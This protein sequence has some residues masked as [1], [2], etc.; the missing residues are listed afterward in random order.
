MAGH[1]HLSR[2]RG[3]PD[4][5]R[6]VEKRLD[7]LFGEVANLRSELN[8]SRVYSQTH[9]HPV[10][11]P[12]PT[13]PRDNFVDY[14]SITAPTRQ[15]PSLLY[16]SPAFSAASG[17]VPPPR[18]IEVTFEKS[19][20]RDAFCSTEDIV[21][22][23]LPVKVPT[24]TTTTTTTTE[25]K[26]MQTAEAEVEGAE[27]E[28]RATEERERNRLEAEYRQAQYVFGADQI[29][30]TQEVRVRVDSNGK[31][32]VLLRDDTLILH[33]VK[34]NSPNKDLIR[35]LG[36][37]LTHVNGTAVATLAEIAAAVKH[38]YSQCTFQLLGDSTPRETAPNEEED[39]S[40][41]TDG[42]TDSSGSGEE[43]KDG[44]CLIM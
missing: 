30:R 27:R 43:K 25:D 10:H 39:S 28:K 13:S 22:E 24:T 14:N 3:P 6:D 11:D 8:S 41:A 23:N 44:C 12:Y 5:G 34:S 36:W 18:V 7:D 20:K 40:D 17:R 9:V 31:L 42:D 19:P 33:D 2:A 29:D 37:T 26:T 32:A 16:G 35:L 21:P 4:G 1:Q 15:H 38:P